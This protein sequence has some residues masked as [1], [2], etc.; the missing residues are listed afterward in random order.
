MHSTSGR[1]GGPVGQHEGS[2]RFPGAAAAATATGCAVSGGDTAA[3]C[4][5]AGTQALLGRR[6]LNQG[7]APRRSELGTLRAEHGGGLASRS[8]AEG[9]EGRLVCPVVQSGRGRSRGGEQRGRIRQLSFERG[10]APP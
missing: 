9:L 6:M 5:R 3:A 1:I 8:N 7:E 2:R 10:Q 4:F